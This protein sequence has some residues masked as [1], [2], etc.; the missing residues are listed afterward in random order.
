MTTWIA[1]AVLFVLIVAGLTRVARRTGAH[2]RGVD[3]RAYSAYE[4]WAEH[5]S[6]RF[7]R[8]RKWEVQ[9]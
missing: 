3:E 2:R 8:E 6:N 4:V 7:Y 5:G 1:F 9:A